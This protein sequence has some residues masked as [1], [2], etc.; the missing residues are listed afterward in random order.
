[1]KTADIKTVIENLMEQYRY[2]I[3]SLNDH[4]HI[5][6]VNWDAETDLPS[7]EEAKELL[8]QLQSHPSPVMSA[9]KVCR[10]VKASER[11]PN[12][13]T[14]VL[15]KYFDTYQELYYKNNGWFVKGTNLVAY[16]EHF[17]LQLEWQEV[18]SPAPPANDGWVSGSFPGWVAELLTEIR[19]R[20]LI[21]ID[22]DG[23]PRS[24]MTE[25]LEMW[26]KVN[27]ALD[28]KTIGVTPPPR[29][30]NNLK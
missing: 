1:M 14:I 24:S 22:T 17:S 16:S 8:K 18:L 28:I 29:N 12:V 6:Y 25:L 26:D 10:W 11:L 7:Y 5:D 27:K 20:L 19:L 21:N 9:E 4:Q 23:N 15:V 2:A 13:G 3:D 30:N